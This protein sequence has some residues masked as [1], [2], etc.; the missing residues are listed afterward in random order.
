MLKGLKSILKRKER[1]IKTS[2]E[3]ITVTVTYGQTYIR[4]V[5]KVGNELYNIFTVY[6]FRFI[7]F[8]TLKH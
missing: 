8:H 6:M 1:T 7:L 2:E 3:T 5:L 4:N